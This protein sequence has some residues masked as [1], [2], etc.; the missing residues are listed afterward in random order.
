MKKA[1]VPRIRL[2]DLRHTLGS[3]LAMVG[4]LIIDATGR[5]EISEGL[6]RAPAAKGGPPGHHRTAADA[7]LPESS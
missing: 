1:G 7:L 2:H 5:R 3:H 4:A 6:P